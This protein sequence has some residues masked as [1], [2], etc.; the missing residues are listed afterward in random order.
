[1]NDH[2]HAEVFKGT[3]GLW[4]WHIKAGNGEVIAQSEGYAG[5]EHVLDVLASHYPDTPVVELEEQP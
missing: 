1:M 3:D 2:D 4:Y 5:K